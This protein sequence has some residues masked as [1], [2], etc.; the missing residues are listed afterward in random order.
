MRARGPLQS[1]MGNV[2]GI[3]AGGIE[4]GGLV[5]AAQKAAMTGNSVA[6]VFAPLLTAVAAAGAVVAAIVTGMLLK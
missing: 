1:I 4:A 2:F 6:A 3:T 5:A